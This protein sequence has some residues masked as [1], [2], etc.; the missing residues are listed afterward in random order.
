MMV[1]DQRKVMR[2]VRSNEILIDKVGFIAP[3]RGKLS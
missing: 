2:M 1:T 3:Q